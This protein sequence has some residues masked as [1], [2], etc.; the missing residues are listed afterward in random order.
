MRTISYYQIDILIIFSGYFL[1]DMTKER[2]LT[3]EEG[4]F[5]LSLMNAFNLVGRTLV[6]FSQIKIKIPVLPFLAVAMLLVGFFAT[7]LTFVD[8]FEGGR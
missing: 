8:Y 6:A 2:G 4:T 7:C 5:L 3:Q 1:L